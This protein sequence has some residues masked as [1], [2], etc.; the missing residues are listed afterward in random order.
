MVFLDAEGLFR[1]RPRPVCK[2]PA[3]SRAAPHPV[4]V[5]SLLSDKYDLKCEY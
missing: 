2:G 1:A 3:C 5:G 4:N